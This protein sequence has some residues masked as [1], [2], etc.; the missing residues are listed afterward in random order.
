MNLL[1][2]SLHWH[3]RDRRDY[4]AGG[5]MFV[6]FSPQ[7]VK[8]EDY[9]GPDVFVVKGTDGTRDRNSWIVW[10]EGGRYPDVIVELASPTTIDTDLGLKK[11]LYERTFRTNEYFCYDPA[12][13]RLFGWKLVRGGYEEIRPDSRGRL[14]S[15]ELGVRLGVWEGELLRARKRWLRFY[16]DEGQLVLTEGEAEAQRAETAEERAE[17]ESEARQA[18]EERAKQENEARQAAEERA[19]QENEARQAAEERAKQENEARQAAE[20]R[21]RKLAEKLRALGID[22]ESL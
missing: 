9:R 17:R 19:K 13:E 15:R 1:I 6:Y 18:A 3:W 14:P 2:D 10:E 11:D 4:F 8:N 5:N 16:T 12:A 7:Q 20:E 21:A 22:P